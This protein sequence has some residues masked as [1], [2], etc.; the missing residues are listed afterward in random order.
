MPDAPRS[1]SNAKPDRASYAN[2]ERRRQQIVEAAIEVFAEN[3]YSGTSLRSIAERAGTSHVSLMHHFGSKEALFQRV[4]ERRLALDQDVRLAAFAESGIE[5]AASVMMKR[6]T[7]SR[8]LIQL[9]ATIQVEAV[10]PNHPAHDYMKQLFAD[11][12][13]EVLEQL[14][15]EESRGV[16]REGLPLPVV[17][18]QLGAL[19]IG[20]Q[21]EWLYDED[22]DMELHVLEFLRLLRPA[23]SA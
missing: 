22:L 17:A 13:K 7:R 23:P 21:I 19:I 3:G 1:T 8:A 14:H 11:T 10:D 2:G 4:L 12:V 18:R 6:N 15:A 16:I 9:D 20:L 5:A